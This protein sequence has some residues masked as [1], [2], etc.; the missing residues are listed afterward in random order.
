LHAEVVVGSGAANLGTKRIARL[1]P[2]EI[3][4]ISVLNVYRRTISKPRTAGDVVIDEYALEYARQFEDAVQEK[5]TPYGDPAYSSP[6]D[7][8]PFGVGGVEA[9]NQPTARNS[10]EAYFSEIK[11]C[12]HGLWTKC[13]FQED[14][15]HYI[16]LSSSNTMWV[17]PARSIKP[18]FWLGGRATKLYDFGAVVLQGWDAKP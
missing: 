2:D 11:N 13:P 5:K 18:S 17:G 10:L 7:A 6:K 15:G 9:G 3:Q 8:I 1:R 12:P 16:L 14:T 4:F